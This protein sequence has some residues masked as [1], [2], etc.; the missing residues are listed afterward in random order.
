MPIVEVK[1]AD[2][3]LIQTY[4]IHADLS[5]GYLTLEDLFDWAKQ[6]AIEDALVTPEQAKTLTFSIPR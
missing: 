5:G 3:T 2:G 1:D 4:E 6:N